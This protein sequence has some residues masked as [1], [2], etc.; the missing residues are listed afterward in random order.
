MSS[1]PARMLN[2]RLDVLKKHL[3]PI[4]TDSAHWTTT[5]RC[6]YGHVYLTSATEYL[7]IHDED[8][9][10]DGLLKM[11]RIY[12][13]LLGD[14]DTFY[15]LGCRDQLK[16]NRGNCTDLNVQFAAKTLINTLNKMF[17]DQRAPSGIRSYRRLA[18]TNAYLALGLLSYGARN[19]QLAR[20]Y[21]IRALIFNPIYGIKHHTFTTIIKS[22]PYVR[23]IG[24]LI[25]T[26]YPRVE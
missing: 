24:H 21:L 15:E 13:E 12:P 1:D 11:V 22:L 17:N 20:G 10:Y 5:Q 18:Y 6:A 4:A 16:G 3:K 9:A 26:N 25:R 8:K 14:L 2:N 23:T 19:Y 7:Q